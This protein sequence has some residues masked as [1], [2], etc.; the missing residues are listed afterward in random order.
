LQLAQLH[1]N[2]Y[3]LD[4]D[5]KAVLEHSTGSME[6]VVERAMVV[7]G[8]PTADKAQVDYDGTTGFKGVVAR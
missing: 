4:V 7:T 8:K 2:R 6:K 3:D 5:P 1:M